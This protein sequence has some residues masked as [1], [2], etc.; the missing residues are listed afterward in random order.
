MQIRLA[1]LLLPILL[2]PLLASAP[3]AQAKF[4][5]ITFDRIQLDPDFALQTS[6]RWGILVNT[7]TVP[8]SLDDDW[9]R[10]LWYAESSDQLGAFFY[11]LLNPFSLDVVLQ[12]GE[13]IG[14]SDPLLLAEL[15]PGETFTTNAL[16]A[17][18]QFGVP[19]PS[20]DFHIDVMAQIGDQIARTRTDVEI[21]D[22]GG[23]AFWVPVSAKRISCELSP[24]SWSS[25]GAPCGESGGQFAELYPYGVNTGGGPP[26]IANWT[27]M[28]TI[29]NW[30]FALRT[31]SPVFQPEMI[32]GFDTAPGSVPVFGCTLLLGLTPALTLIPDSVPF[33][34]GTTGVPIP[35]NPALV[36][37]TLYFQSAV[38]SGGLFTSQGA[39]ITFGDVTV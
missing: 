28:P 14:D 24:V 17:T 22:L 20:Q 13:A 33:F 9:E 26:W 35:T 27:N 2:G 39:A 8:I 12:P 16:I 4:D 10:G 32:L 11:D 36:G 38:L 6:T 1:S 31:Q 5:Y 30:A 21:T 15:L 23:A 29:G 18:F 34:T 7:G 3:R 19:F 37:A 25:Y